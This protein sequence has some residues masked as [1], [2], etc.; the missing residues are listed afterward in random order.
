MVKFDDLVPNSKTGNVPIIGEVIPSRWAFEALSVAS[1]S[2]NQYEKPIF[3]DEKEKYAAQYYRHAFLYEMESQLETLEDERAKGVE[4][5]PS[6]LSVIKNELPHLSSICEMDQYD[7]IEKL[8]EKT[9]TQE[10]YTSLDNYF[11]EAE[12]ILNRRCS[13]YNNECDRIITDY[14]AANGKE[15]LLNLKRKHYNLFLEDLVI[16]SDTETTHKIVGNAIVPKAG[17]IFID[18]R[19]HNGRAPFYSSVKIVSNYKIPTLWYNLGVLIL[20]CIL[21]TLALFLDFPG[22]F[23]RRNE[24]E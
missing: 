1:F 13:K 17:Y 21:T 16:N 24:R 22:R 11:T 9:F 14:I 18:P 19:T 2:M 10:I 7:E 6:H 12:N 8:S 4:M 15:A 5:K 20:M 23:I 3:A